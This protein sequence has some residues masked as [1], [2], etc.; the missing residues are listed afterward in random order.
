MSWVRTLVEC[1][2][3]GVH[4]T[5]VWSHGWPSGYSRCLSDMKCTVMIWRSKK[6]WSSWVRTMVMSNLGCIVLLSKVVLEPKISFHKNA[7]YMYLKVMANHAIQQWSW[8]QE[9][10]TPMLMFTSCI[11]FRSNWDRHTNHVLSLTPQTL[12]HEQYI[13]KALSVSQTSPI[14]P[15]P[16]TICINYRGAKYHTLF[17]S[18][19]S[20]FIFFASKQKVLFHVFTVCW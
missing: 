19:L 14:K 7:T 5:S 1:V 3:L 6:I 20:T 8:R 10:S 17:N 15:D 2:E 9:T 4:S 12:H 16:R 13:F 18:D 11:L